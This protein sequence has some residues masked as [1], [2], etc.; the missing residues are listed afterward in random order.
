MQFVE[1]GPDIPERLLQLHE[2]GEVVFFC[3][4]GI[5]FPA[6]LPGFKD[7]VDQ[8][9][10]HF[11]V[12]FSRFKE[13]AIKEDGPDQAIKF[14]EDEVQGGRSAVRQKLPG[15]LK[16]KTNATETHGALLDLSRSRE[17]NTRLVTTNFDRLFEE[18]ID[19]KGLDIDCFQAPALPV[20]KKR[21]DG[22]VYLHGLLSDKPTSDEL[23]SLVLSSGDFGLAYLTERWAARFVSELFRRFTVCFIGYSLG[24]PVLRYIVDAIAADR[25]LGESVREIFAFASFSTSKQEEK[26]KWRAKGVTSILYPEDNNHVSLH[27]TLE[28][29]A[30]EYRYGVLGKEYTVV[31]YASFNPQ[32][33]TEQNNFVGRLL[34]AISDASGLPAKRFAEF[35]PVPSLDWLWIFSEPRYFQADLQRF[36]VPPQKKLD[37]NLKFSLI[38]RPTPYSKA[39]LMS[40]VYAGDQSSRWDEIMFHLAN[41]LLR[42][43]NDPKLLLWFVEQRGQLHDDLVLLIEERLNELVELEDK[44][45]VDKLNSISLHAPNAIPSQSMR[46]LWQLLLTR[47]VRPR[48][49][50]NLLRWVKR[51]QLYGLTGTLRIELRDMLTP[52]VR[53]RPLMPL[54]EVSKEKNKPKSISDLVAREVVLLSDGP[55]H[56]LGRLSNDENWKRELPTLFTCFTELLREALDLMRELGRADDRYDPSYAVQRS[57]SEHS[58][59]S[60]FTDWAA[61]IRLTRDAWCALAKQDPQ[62]AMREAEN[63]MGISYPLFRRLAFFAAAELE[64]MP[65]RQKL[66]WLLIDGNWWLWS[67]ETKREVMRLLVVLVPELDGQM[68]IEL[69]QAILKGPPP[70][71]FENNVD[72]KQWGKRMDGMIW[73]RLEKIKQSRAVLSKVTQ[74]KLEQISA[75]NK[76]WKL[77]ADER[78]EFPVWNEVGDLVLVNIP[79][80]RKELVAWLKK[81]PNTVNMARLQQDDWRKRCQ[82]DFP[83]TACT[84]LQLV[85]EDCWLIERWQQALQAWSNEKHAQRSWRYMAKVITNVPDEKIQELA[86]SIS[87]WLEAIALNFTRQEREFFSIVERILRLDYPDIVGTI[88]LVT[89]AINHPVG[90]VTRALLSWWNTGSLEEGQGL[91]NKLKTIFTSLCDTGIKKYRH[92]RLLLAA[93]IVTLFSVD[94][95]WTKKYLLPLFNWEVSKEEARIAWEGFLSLPQLYRPLMEAMKTVF[96]DTAKHYQ[97][98]KENSAAEQYAALLLSASLDPGDTFTEEELK[99]ATCAI[100]PKGREIAIQALWQ[101]L[102]ATGDKRDNFWND[103]VKPYLLL[104]W[105]QTKEYTSE[106]IA[107][108]LGHLCV[109]AGENFPEAFETL[110]FWLEPIENPIYLITRLHQADICKDHPSEALKFLVLIIDNEEEWKDPLTGTYL[111]HS[112]L[113]ECL[114][115]I[116]Q[117]KPELVETPEYKELSTYIP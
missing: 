57:I 69:E 82:D 44:N 13:V 85:N 58:Q 2:E 102:E 6:G 43:L 61:L 117:S 46:T 74:A 42:H 59:N 95:D 15:I 45:E 98:F 76:E 77:S 109:A 78:D 25:L 47:R 108:Q 12:D 62:M 86:H 91:S 53:L 41:W 97:D 40:L 18:V 49:D 3:G 71:M 30:K 90:L 31:N 26:N 10:N 23:D 63:W 7:L 70:E 83:T 111:K 9:Y 55:H 52:K 21:W 106:G 110:R 65:C 17:G 60:T 16:P 94:E 115:Q 99:D 64:E 5:S 89:K 113:R 28:K 22:I 96:L 50:L 35:N 1:K 79:L 4:A 34:W 87:Q 107:E 56:F 38:Q 81:N 48:Q 39:P 37:K 112:K 29:W 116:K 54:S 67:L 84:L 92:G 8:L 93:N 105:P 88:D 103:R 32:A 19:Q 75:Q 68:L 101:R 73:Q 20:P 80:R 100:S 11:G 24:D 66:D 36:G 14:L 51:F 104:I 114:E 27:T 33:S 72:D